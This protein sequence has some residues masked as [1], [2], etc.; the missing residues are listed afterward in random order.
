MYK[1]K[2]IV[3]APTAECNLACS[4]CRV[5]RRRGQSGNQI[6][7]EAAVA[8]LESC[9]THEIDR[10]GFSGGEPFLR[11]DFLET[12]CAACVERGLYFD[13]L[14]TN[15]VWAESEEAMRETLQHVYDAGFDGTIAISVDDYHNQSPASLALFIRAV[16][17]IWK[18]ADCIELVSVLD[19]DGNC[20]M[21]LFEA[22]AVELSAQVKVE[23]GLPLALQDKRYLDNFKRGMED[24][25]GLY[26]PIMLMPYSAAADDPAAWQA[27]RWF[28]DDY[29]EGPGQIFYVH[30]D[31][32][33]SV[34][35]GFANENPQLIL[36]TVADGYDTL[37]EAAEANPQVRI[38]YETGL[39]KKRQEM[40]AAGV[41]FPG[42]TDDI[43]FFCDY[44]CR[45]PPKA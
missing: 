7:A 40:E 21:S 41:V 1:P 29:C 16:F 32:A 22:L 34:C 17:K 37:M 10:V 14:M 3:F 44:V 5:D 9:S 45:L 30:P 11:P 33:V 26:M 23:A 36:G 28:R 2:Q 42:K 13:R 20:A 6:S 12:V 18:R 15:G 8:F 35:C 24:G 39:G 4:H 38:C 19:R 31:G 27:K 25:S 43:C